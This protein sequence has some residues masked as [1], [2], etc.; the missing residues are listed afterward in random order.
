MDAVLLMSFQAVFCCVLVR[1]SVS[2]AIGLTLSADAATAPDSNTAAAKARVVCFFMT[3]PSAFLV[4][5]TIALNGKTR[6]E[7]ARFV[8][9]RSWSATWRRG[10]V[11]C[12]MLRRESSPS[13][14]WGG[15]GGGRE[16]RARR[17]RLSKASRPPPL[18]PPHKGRGTC[19]ANA[20]DCAIRFRIIHREPGGRHGERPDAQQQGKEEAEAGQEQGQGC[21]GPL[22]VRRHAQPG[23]PKAVRQEIADASRSKHPPLQGEVD[24]RSASGWGCAPMPARCRPPCV[25]AGNCVSD[26]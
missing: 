9:S 19:T 2:W 17:R 24:A 7:N 16:V 18:T 14:L 13:P 8:T 4:R 3:I 22:T 10:F 15:R 25:V 12:A 11:V 20:L 5:G 21:P 6:A 26:N 1:L 23:D